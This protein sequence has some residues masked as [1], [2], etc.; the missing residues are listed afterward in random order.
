MKGQRKIEYFSLLFTFKNCI[1]SKKQ[2]E[3]KKGR[4]CK[5]ALFSERDTCSSNLRKND[6][7]GFCEFV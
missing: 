4:K 1:S 3:G 7:E 6:L 5:K 2:Q